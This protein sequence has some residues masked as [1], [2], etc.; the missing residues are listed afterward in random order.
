MSGPIPHASYQIG[1]AD[2]PWHWDSYSESGQ[3][4]S[5]SQHYETMPTPDIIALREELQLDWIFD[6]NAALIMW[7]TW[8]MLAR[9]DAHAVMKGWGFKPVSGGSWHKITKRSKDTFGNGYMFRDS[10]EP[11]LVGIRGTGPGLPPRGQRNWRNGFRAVR[12]EHSRKPIYLHKA[13]EKMYPR[14]PRIEFFSR[15]R[16]PGWDCWGK[17]VGKFNGEATPARIKQHE[18]APTLLHFMGAL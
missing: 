10:C 11:F 14:G 1:L 5:A 17:E 9:G 18:G 13:I 12:Q 8:T 15:E 2:P 3:G 16:R 6:P 4:K 7:T